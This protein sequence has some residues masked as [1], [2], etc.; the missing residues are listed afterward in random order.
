[1]TDSRSFEN[2]EPDEIPLRVLVV[3]DNALNRALMEAMLTPLGC[4]VSLAENGEAASGIARANPFD[5]IVMDLQ[6]P[7]L[8]GDGATRRIRAEGASRQAFVVRWTTEDDTR[9]NRE[10]YDGELPK[11][12]TCSPLIAAVSL[13]S[14]RALYRMDIGRGESWQAVGDRQLR[15]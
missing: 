3:D 2:S 14:R 1:M 5:L 7:V 9:L 13:A 10:L 11:P 4:V 12:L 8:D 15:R 6:M